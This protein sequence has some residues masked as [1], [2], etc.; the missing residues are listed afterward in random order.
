MRGGGT[1]R[2]AD[3]GVTKPGRVGR[4]GRISVWRVTHS[5]NSEV[6]YS[7][8]GADVNGEA[9]TIACDVATERFLQL[10]LPCLLPRPCSLTR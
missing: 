10:P 3:T 8:A 6:K 4:S 7:E 5:Y 1:V 2:V 9:T